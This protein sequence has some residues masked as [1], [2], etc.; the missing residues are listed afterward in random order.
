MWG[1]W[2]NDASAY[3]RTLPQTADNGRRFRVTVPCR[4]NKATRHALRIRRQ[5]AHAATS[6]EGANNYRRSTLS[7]QP[8]CR[9]SVSAI[10]V[11]KSGRVTSLHD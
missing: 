7:L 9:Y 2:V 4:G 11:R 5:S 8:T 10:S 1:V 3:R 6:D